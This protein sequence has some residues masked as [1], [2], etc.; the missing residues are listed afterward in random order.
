MFQSPPKA[1]VNHK[2][3]SKLDPNELLVHNLKSLDQLDD[4][5]EDHMRSKYEKKFMKK[6]EKK[7]ISK[8][9][10]KPFVMG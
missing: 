2:N 4:I 10:L 5:I 9:L 6:T 3:W 1:G 7:Q 8:S